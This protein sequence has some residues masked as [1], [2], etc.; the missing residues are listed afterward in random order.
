MNAEEE[1]GIV[2]DVCSSTNKVH[3]TVISLGADPRR[4]PLSKGQITLK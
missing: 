4:M 3:S 1:V 2:A